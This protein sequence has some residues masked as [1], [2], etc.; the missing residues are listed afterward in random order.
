MNWRRL[1]AVG[2][3]VGVVGGISIAA[4]GLYAVIVIGICRR[5]IGLGEQVSVFAIGIPCFLILLIVFIRYLPNHLRKSGMLS[6]NPERF[7]PWFK[8]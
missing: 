1:Y 4:A 8:K 3:I 6:D 2:Q 5:L 7:G